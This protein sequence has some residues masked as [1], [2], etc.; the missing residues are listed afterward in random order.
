MSVLYS[1]F[2][3]AA[4]CRLV[5]AATELETTVSGFT[6]SGHHWTR[7]FAAQHLGV[8][9]STLASRSDLLKIGGRWLE[10][11]YPTVQFAPEG[12]NE[13]VAGIVGHLSDDLDPSCVCDWLGRPNV[14][15]S[16]STPI[17]WVDSGRPLAK[18]L[19]AVPDTDWLGSMP[20]AG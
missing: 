11:V 14:K 1:H 6:L 16:G 2:S 12:L 3:G 9:P 7:D 19:E 18:V 13:G 10:E 8:Q 4:A 20:A 17:E 5:A 15:L